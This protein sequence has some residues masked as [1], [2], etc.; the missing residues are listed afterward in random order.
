MFHTNQNASQPTPQAD[1]LLQTAQTIAYLDSGKIK[2]KGIVDK[3]FRLEQYG[4]ALDS[5]QN[6][7]AVKV[8]IV[9][10]D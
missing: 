3:T 5:I 8:A 9:F 1:S 7:T 2:T 10:D 6:K 4:E